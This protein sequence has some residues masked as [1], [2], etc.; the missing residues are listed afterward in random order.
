MKQINN[1]LKK[2]ALILVAFMLLV[3]PNLHVYSSIGSYQIASSA[4]IA[5]KNCSNKNNKFFSKNYICYNDYLINGFY[6][7]DRMGIIVENHI[8]QYPDIYAKALAHAKIIAEILSCSYNGHF[9]TSKKPAKTYAKYDFS[10][11]DN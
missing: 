1:Y 2:G 7:D 6:E 8:A 5:N 11:F 10:G 9:S 4:I 3:I